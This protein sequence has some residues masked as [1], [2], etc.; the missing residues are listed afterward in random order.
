MTDLK[1]LFEK[2]DF[3]KEDCLFKSLKALQSLGVD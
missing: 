3:L 2:I 1:H